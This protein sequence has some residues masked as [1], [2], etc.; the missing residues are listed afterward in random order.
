MGDISTKLDKA[1]EGKSFADLADAPVAALQGVSDADAQ[2]LKQ[3]FGIETVRD[4]GTSKYFLWA[5]AITKLA[6]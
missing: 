1:Y 3:A 5:Q 6:D 4:L 2:H